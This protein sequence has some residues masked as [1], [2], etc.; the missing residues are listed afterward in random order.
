MVISGVAPVATAWLTKSVLDELIAGA[1]AG[2]L[3]T[4]GVV[5]A[6]V[7]AVAGTL[8]HLTQFVRAELDR[9]VAL[10][11]QERLFT[12]VGSY[13]GLGRFEDPRFVD[14]LRLADQAGRSTPS[15]TVDCL[16]GSV[17]SSITIAGFLGS[18]LLLSPVMAALVL[19]SGVP[20]LLAQL[21]LSRRRARM[22]LSI[23]PAERRELF[24]SHLMTGA[25][26]AKEVRLFGTGAFL[27]GRML[28]DRR[29]ADTAKRA[30][31]RRTML[32][33][34]GLGVLAALVSGGGLL[35]AVSAAN[36]G[37]FS[38]GGITMFV[39]AVAGVQA[40]LVTLTGQVAGTHQALLLFDH[41]AAVTTAE[42]DLPL[43][44][45]P[46]P[47]RPLRHGI[48]LR[49][50]WFR[51]SDEH[52]WVLRGVNLFIPHGTSMALVGLNGTGKS[53]LVKMMCRF[54]DPTRGAILWDG[55]D[56]RDVDPTALR[57]R[58]G[59]V[60]QDYV[61]YDM[62]AAENIGVGNLS[63]F[64]DRARLEDAARRAGIH[65]ALLAL[66]HGY[67]TLLSRVFFME[68]EKDDPKT[69][70]ALSGGQWQR[71]ALARALL[72]DQ[73]DLMILDE[74]SAGLDAQA[75]AEIHASL[76]KYRNGRTSLLISHRLG[77]VRNADSIVVLANGRVTE[78]G[79]HDS[80]MAARGA[81]ARLF[82]LQAS[83]YRTG[84][85]LSVSLGGQS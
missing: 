57:E 53:T 14:Q 49:D 81:Y 32:V 30:V 60:F 40:T 26:S 84:G 45:A 7:S 46:C 28:N 73:R 3:V 21:S 47:L 66:P 52:P 83:G 20:M 72:R 50:V 39:A 13:V 35:W 10:L 31:D 33:Q 79:D 85:D 74:P 64:G 22:L 58:I 15:Q 65:D 70:V 12:A 67:D 80:L 36:T 29:A 6:G 44:V 38:V 5:L 42:P 71:L 16:L 9:A 24:Y 61:Q 55:V 8:P 27:R 69:G 18:L 43:A 68:S 37:A 75:E 51:Y 76:A 17:R 59:T 11:A 2:R 25:D 78:Q 82:L 41:Y 34:T 48:E 1:P 19:L 54:Y 77:A 4:L 62:T 63:M 23:G 56:L